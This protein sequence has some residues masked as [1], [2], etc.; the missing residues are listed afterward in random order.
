MA[1]NQ[2]LE[3][4]QAQNLAMTP[5]MQQSIKLLQMTHLELGQFVEQQLVENPLLEAP[6]TANNDGFDGDAPPS[7]LVSW[8]GP[9]NVA[10]IVRDDGPLGAQLEAADGGLDNVWD[11][12]DSAA[13]LQSGS[14]VWGTGS[15]A[16]EDGP[17]WE[18][19]TE[20]QPSLQDHL[21]AQISLEF[22]DPV[23]RRIAQL[24]TDQLDF[25]G[26][27]TGNFSELAFMLGVECSRVSDVHAAFMQLDPVGIGACDLA[28]C[29]RQQMA[30]MGLLDEPMSLLLSNL[31]L[32]GKGD[33]EVLARRCGV[34]LA[35]LRDLLSQIRRCNPKPA[36]MFDYEPAVTLVPDV[37][38]R[39]GPALDW[40]I[41][42]NPDALPKVVAD[43]RYY[44]RVRG[45]AA[46]RK[47]TEYFTEQ[48]QAANWLVRALDQRANTI[49]NVASTIVE[50]QERFFA[51]GVEG[52]KPMTL[53]DVA[54]AISMHEST[55][56]RVTTGKYMATPRGT[57]ELKFFFTNAIASSGN[58]Q[59]HSAEAVRHRLRQMIDAETSGNV[60]SDDK[61]VDL[62][63]A[64]GVIVARRT[65]AK[66][67][68]A[69]NIPSSA[70]RK[71]LQR[72]AAG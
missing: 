52:L 8:D 71:R 14:L 72:L 9:D 65:V 33:F 50:E 11:S 68:E 7:E 1:I 42:L 36:S 41:E 53:R 37:F 35:E 70:K 27:F 2:R 66:Y 26:Y 45:Q 46:D 49:L 17:G 13:G 43:R 12:A 34:S 40:E 23:D 61:L 22:Q 10:E 16:G 48:W 58:D 44:N 47:S 51:I 60:L 31:S 4:R 64:D 32:V 38:V 67:R 63:A 28:Q 21:E 56:S 69:M 3:I 54:D 24:L 55:V 59:A 20:S 62:L 25:S 19:Q 57:F 39:R 29:L 18:A 30:E 6:D 5:Q 15:M